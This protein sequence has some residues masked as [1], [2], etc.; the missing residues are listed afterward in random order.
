VSDLTR[1]KR[2]RE[3]GENSGTQGSNNFVRSAVASQHDALYPRPDPADLF[4]QRQIFVELLS[5]CDYD[6]ERLLAQPL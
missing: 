1:V 3:A 2:G 4:K 5:G 6:A